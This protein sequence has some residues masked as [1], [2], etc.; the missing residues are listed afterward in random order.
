M[1]SA[2]PT[3]SPTS[4]AAPTARPGTAR[5]TRTCEPSMTRRRQ[6]GFTYLTVL[7]MVAFM[8]LGMAMAGK[9]Y[10]TAVLREREVELLW[11]GNQY[12]LA[13]EAYTKRGGGL[14]PRSLDDL[15]RDPRDPS[16]RRYLRRRYPD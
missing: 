5:R 1:P 4:R 15:L 7:F 6:S 11:R 16:V 12:R 2:A 9:V 3:A 13:I 10:R 14:Y 8:G